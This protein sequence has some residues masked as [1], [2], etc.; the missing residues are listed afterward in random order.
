MGPDRTSSA[1]TVVASGGPDGEESSSEI[2]PAD[3]EAFMAA[4]GGCYA[5]SP[6]T[7]GD[8][9]RRTRHWSGS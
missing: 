2:A 6:K 3:F 1:E 8:G 9:W 7:R 5:S 4:R